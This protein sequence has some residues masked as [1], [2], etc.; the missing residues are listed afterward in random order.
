[1]ER[2]RRARARSKTYS[3]RPMHR[4]PLRPGAPPLPDVEGA[5]LG[6]DGVGPSPLGV[7]NELPATSYLN[8]LS[9]VC[10]DIC[11][12]AAVFTDPDNPDEASG[13][14]VAGVPFHVRLGFINDGEEP[15]GDGFDL[16]V[17]V[18]PMEEGDFGIGPTTRYSSD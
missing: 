3:R 14:W 12:R 5:V 15:L 11:L 4:E 1:M 10:F 17:Y 13:E 18:F 7:V 2:T 9:E 8:F 16:V 6:D